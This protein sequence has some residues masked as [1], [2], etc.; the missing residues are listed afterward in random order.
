M[1]GRWQYLMNTTI[2]KLYSSH[3]NLMLHIKILDVPDIDL[4]VTLWSFTLRAIPFSKGGDLNIFGGYLP[5]QFNYVDPHLRILNS[6][7]HLEPPCATPSSHI[8]N[9]LIPPT[10]GAPQGNLWKWNSPNSKSNCHVNQI[11]PQELHASCNCTEMF[12][13]KSPMGS[14]LT[15]CD[16]FEHSC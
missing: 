2:K 4:C 3:C 15:L 1:G 13:T 11:N 5:P 8:L 14:M 10:P 7:L 6:I 9:Y 12:T 16:P